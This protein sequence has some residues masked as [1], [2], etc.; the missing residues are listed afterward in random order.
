MAQ[1]FVNIDRQTPMLLPP[2]LREWVPADHLARL[3]VDA[4]EMCALA[5][6][7]VNVRGTG[8]AQYPPSMMLGLLIY[9][10]ANSIFASR[11]IEA[12][13]FENVAVRFICGD[14]HPDHA[15]IASFRRENQKLFDRCFGQVLLVAQEAGLLRMGT[16]SLDGSRLAG[17]GSR[18]AVR[19]LEQI[20]AEYQALGGQLRAQAEQLDL[21]EN[22]SAS[23]GQLPPELADGGR[24]REQLLAAKERIEARRQAARQAGRRDGPQSAQRT[25][26]AS[27]SEPESRTLRR[28]PGGEVIQ[29]Y[30]VQ[31]AVD[32]G[33]SGLIVG[34]HLS[35]EPTDSSQLLPTLEAVAPEIERPTVVLVDK[36]YD[37]AEHIAQ[38][39]AEQAVMVLCPPQ[40][41]CNEQPGRVRRGREARVYQLRQGMKERLAQPHW[42]A[43]YTRRKATV[44]TVFA[45]IK[46]NLGFRR[47]RCWGRR[48]AAAEWALVC[49]AH[50][51]RLLAGAARQ[52]G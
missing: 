30:N 1:R 4:T 11:R 40:A 35:D 49:L 33:T 48:A 32:A 27:V 23:G 21:V 22:E 14:S 12:A 42:A 51:L 18:A 10:Y 47:F 31:V 29:G 15:T 7:R 45:R 17:A 46:T 37:H 41:R 25:S 39:E 43:L 36:G 13:T 38:A 44:E 28:G 19:T 34:H 24:R 16:I 2:D 8:S 6:A 20:E 50:N 52:L 3:I 9:C 5:E 26:A